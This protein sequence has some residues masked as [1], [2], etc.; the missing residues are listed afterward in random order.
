MVL[1]SNPTILDG[2]LDGFS[3]N[4]LGFSFLISNFCSVLTT[5]ASWNLIELLQKSQPKKVVISSTLG[6]PDP[7]LPCW[8]ANDHAW[9]SRFVDEWGIKICGVFNK[10]HRA[11]WKIPDFLNKNCNHPKLTRQ[12]KIHHLKM[13][14]LLNMGIFQCH[15]SFPGCNSFNRSMSKTPSLVVAL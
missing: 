7:W 1:I 5:E 2:I 14:F 3:C 6:E 15:V 9:W 11:K 8:H 10:K 4:S 13:Y 12:W